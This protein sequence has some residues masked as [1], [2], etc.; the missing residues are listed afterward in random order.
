MH[1]FQGDEKDTIIFSPGIT[2]G[3]SEKTYEWLKNNK[4][5]INVAISRAKDQLIIVS[6]VDNIK[7]LHNINKDSP[8]D[9]YELVNYVQ[10]VGHSEVS[11]RGNNSRA[12]GIKPFSTETEAAFFKNLNLALENIMDTTGR[13]R[14]QKEVPLKQVFCENIPPVDLFYTGQFDFVV[15]EKNFAG[16][17][18]PVLAI[19]LDGKEHTDDAAVRERDRKK[20]YIC[21]EHHFQ[22]IRVDNTYARRYYSIKDILMNYFKKL[23]SR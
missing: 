20:N 14:V 18:Q 9:F 2:G 6:D 21:A 19:E 1:S 13:Y 11:M 22:L 16:Q 10:S 7:R 8:D 4:E 17:E 23:N 5:L 15:F 3:T 12:L